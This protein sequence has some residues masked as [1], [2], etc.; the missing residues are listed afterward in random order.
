MN[1]PVSA[2]AL[3]VASAGRFQSPWSRTSCP[4]RA[5]TRSAV[6]SYTNTLVVPCGRAGAVAVNVTWASGQTDYYHQSSLSLAVNSSCA[7]PSCECAASVDSI[8]RGSASLSG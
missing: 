8:V 2:E 6:R 3:V 1:F 7:L 5:A 4:N